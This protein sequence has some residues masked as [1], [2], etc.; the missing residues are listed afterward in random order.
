MV[1]VRLPANWSVQPKQK[2]NG[3]NAREKSS[4]RHD[5]RNKYSKTQKMKLSDFDRLVK[6][7]I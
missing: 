2:K 4:G 1:F 7:L 3:Q 6:K 5:N